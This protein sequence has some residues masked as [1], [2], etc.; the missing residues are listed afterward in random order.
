MKLYS[1]LC[2]DLYAKRILKKEW[3]YV[4]TIHFAVQKELTQLC[5]STTIISKRKASRIKAGKF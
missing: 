5:K 1:T 2:E 4:E 3:L